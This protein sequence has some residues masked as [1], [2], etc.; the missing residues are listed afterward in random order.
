MNKTKAFIILLCAFALITA[1]LKLPAQKTLTDTDPIKYYNNAVELLQN[2][3][4]NAASAMFQTYIDKGD[5]YLLKARSQFFIALCAKEL[6]MDNTEDLFLSF[7]EKYPE[8]GKDN[9]VFI[10]L[11]RFYFYK[12]KYEEAL[13]WLS[14]IDN[15]NS[16]HQKDRQEFYFMSGYCHFKADNYPKA[17]SD[18]SQLDMED[19]PYFNPANYYKGYIYYKQ[20]KYENAL[21]SFLKIS[22]DDKLQRIIPAYVT[23]IYLSY[24]KYND[25][26]TYGEKALNTPKVERV[27]DIKSYLAEAYFQLKEYDKAILYYTDLKNSGYKFSE[28]DYYNFAYALFRKEEY[29]KS[30]EMFSNVV[31]KEDAL[32]QNVA[33]LMGTSYL[34]LDEKQKAKNMFSF[35][36]KFKFDRTTQEISAL[37]NAKLSYELGYDKEAINTLVGIIAE[38]PPSPYKDDAQNL[39]GQ[40]LLNT[41][42]HKEAID[43]IDGLSVRNNSIN[44]AYQVHTY[45]YG[46]EYFQN[47]KYPSARELFVKSIRINVDRKYTALAS[48]WLGETYFQTNELKAAQREYQNFLYN[49]ESKKTPYYAIAFYNMAYTYFKLEDYSNARSNFSKYLTLETD[50]TRSDRYDDAFI[51]QADCYFGVKDYE[52]ALIYY[53]QSISRSRQEVDYAMYQKA[54]IL[55]LIGKNAEKTEVLRLLTTRYPNSP[56]MDDALFE[57]ANMHFLNGEYQQAQAKFNYVVQEFPKSPYYTAALLRIGL[58]NYNMDQ[59]EKALDQFLTIMDKYPYSPEAKEAFKAAREIYIDMG[60]GSEL[61]KMKPGLA[62][63]SQDSLLYYS[64]FSHV[65]KGNCDDAIKALKDYLQKNPSGYF[66]VNANYYIASCALGKGMKAVALEHFE[67]VNQMSPNEFV[68]NSLKNAADIY[69][70]DRNFEKALT[71]FTQLEEIGTMRTNT[72]WAMLGEMR[73][74]FEL[75]EFVQCI[76]LAEKILNLS[77][78]SNDEKTEAHYYT[79][80]SYFKLNKY[81]QAMTSFGLVIKNNMGDFGAESKYLIANIYFLQ[82]KYDLAMDNILE[83][84]DEYANNDYFVAKGFILLS[85]VFVKMGDNFQAKSTL[86]SIIDNYPKEDLKQIAEEKL[87]Q[88]IEAELKTEKENEQKKSEEIELENQ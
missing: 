15:P 43:I 69:Y 33:F 67:V 76:S 24:K 28:S 18:F 49:S 13:K 68:E 55:G 81:D 64:A 51:R 2:K 46:L 75:D 32:G 63:S 83:L 62:K 73:C 61:I 3:K 9:A 35:A 30:L 17:L 54:V 53:D 74:Y 71:R 31:I 47:K 59:T 41:P 40:L 48:F 50:N 14:D 26:V 27:Q 82:E 22:S 23:H 42:N 84:K 11:G 85:D 39:L 45:F 37:N 56:Y 6:N 34:I 77:Y 72:L 79:G 5:D 80:K 38:F 21:K 66:V 7:L 70:Q 12:K 8:Q 25:V 16:F 29:R 1:S 36:A 20:G 19:N 88:I 58:A 4:Y 87:Q 44:N 86:K 52:N 78:A 60:K 65:K 10:E 57:I